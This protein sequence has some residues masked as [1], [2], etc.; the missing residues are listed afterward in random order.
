VSDGR[1]AD[2]SATPAQ[3]IRE[4]GSLAR[5]GGH[6]RTPTECV[7]HRLTTVPHTLEPS[8][9]ESTSLER[10]DSQLDELDRWISWHREDVERHRQLVEAELPRMVAARRAKILADRGELH[11]NIG[12]TLGAGTTLM[13]TRFRCD[14]ARAPIGARSVLHCPAGRNR[15][16]SNTPEPS[17]WRRG[18]GGIHGDTP[19]RPRMGTWC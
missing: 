4:P 2:R 11:A 8:T 5:A 14:G 6:G 3:G 19:T 9:M 17:T 18:R 12:S 15:R 16:N 7:A 1:Q 10:F 13:L